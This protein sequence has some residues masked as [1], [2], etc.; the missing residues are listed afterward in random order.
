MKTNS[1]SRWFSIVFVLVLL[2]ASLSGCGASIVGSPAPTET[3]Q[4]NRIWTTVGSGGTVDEDDAD[5]VRFNRGTVQVGEFIGQNQ[6]L[7][8]P[9]AQISQPE[10]AVIRYNVTPVDGL[11]SLRG[12]CREDLAECP[13][14]GLEVRYLAIGP[15]ARVVV[16]LVEVNVATGIEVDRLTLDSKEF[17]SARDYQVKRAGKCFSPTPSWLFDFRKKAYYVEATL[18]HS[19]IVAASAAGIHTIKI[20]NDCRSDVNPLS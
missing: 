17:E 14:V 15:D 3:L 16:K 8:A 11:F 18:T 13:G 9:R 20:L 7:S 10:S 1:L 4:S 2:L 5:E 19:S 6:G 12:P